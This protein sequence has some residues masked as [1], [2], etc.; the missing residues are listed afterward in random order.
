MLIVWDSIAATSTNRELDA[1]YG[2]ATVGEHARIISQAM[3]KLVKQI[4]KKKACAL[5]LNQTREKIGVMFGD[6]EDTFGGKAVPFYASVRIRL[7]KGQK[8]TEGGKKGERVIGIGAR[9]S[10]VKNKVAEPFREAEMPI[11]FGYGID[12]AEASLELLKDLDHVK[13]GGAWYTLPLNGNEL[14]FQ[15]KEWPDL[16]YDNAEAVRELVFQKEE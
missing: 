14:R 10:N 15:K 1:N 5:F 4:S 11:Y 16:Y 3:R 8:I 7:K 12:D 13:V 6:K 2:S 9:V